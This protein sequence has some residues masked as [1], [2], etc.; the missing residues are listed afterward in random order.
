M[1][2]PAC[3]TRSW[4]HRSSAHHLEHH[5]FQSR[6]CGHTT[7]TG[8]DHTR[9]DTG[10]CVGGATPRWRIKPSPEVL[11][12]HT[13]PHTH[14]RTPAPYRRGVLR[15]QPSAWTSGP[16]HAPGTR[17]HVTRLHVTPLHVT[18][19]HVARL[20]DF[21]DTGTRHTAKR[22]VHT[23]MHVSAPHP[24]APPGTRPPP[25]RS[26]YTSAHGYKA[27]NKHYYACVRAS[28]GSCTPTTTSSAS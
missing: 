13:W 18:R 19:L 10:P 24:A 14:R 11:A 1:N 22:L 28:P 6:R 2:L 7:F 16:P 12:S 5:V 3:T 27:S 15:R 25:C 23:A 26:C 9:Q 20:H 17:L 21:T 4:C 8:P